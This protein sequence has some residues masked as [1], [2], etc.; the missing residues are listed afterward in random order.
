VQ[1]FRDPFERL[2]VW[3]L[4]EYLLQLTLRTEE[5]PT[6][7]ERFRFT[8]FESDSVE[9]RSYT[10]DYQNGGRITCNLARHSGIVS[11]ITSA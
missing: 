9:L 5:G 6:F 3:L 8:L 7:S 4:G 1:P 2:F 11:P 10:D